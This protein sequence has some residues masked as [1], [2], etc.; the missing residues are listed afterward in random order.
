MNPN[1]A[2]TTVP[3]EGWIQQLRP[4]GLDPVVVSHEAGSFHKWLVSQGIAAYQVSLPFPNKRWPWRF[5]QSILQLRRIVRR[6]RIDIIHCNEQNIYPIGNYLG[7]SCG[8]P[9]VVS[10]HCRMEAGFVEWA[11]GGNRRPDRM[12]F[13][14]YASREAC[15]AAVQGVVPESAWGLLANGLDLAHYCPDPEL[16][17]AFRAGHGINGEPVVGAACA[18]RPGKQVEHLADATALLT[19]PGIRVILA[20]FPI[21]GEEA[22][23]A[24]VLDYARGRLGDRLIYLS[25]ETDLRGF[26]NALDLCVNTSQAETC[27]IS[28]LEAL[29]CGCPVVGYPSTSVG[30]QVLPSGGEIVEQDNIDELAGAVKRWLMDGRRLADSRLGARR[31]AET[32]YDIRKLAGQLWDEYQA[33]LT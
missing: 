6:H 7:R 12:F 16:R 8:L 32:A 27:S 20:A 21:R 23:A 3:T 22:Y 9:V 19:V 18:L 11:F 4:K 2:S 10:V 24:R 13:L 30:E 29:A 14:T 25:G 5:L 31:R 26:Y 1:R 33:L 15:R 17:T 28:I